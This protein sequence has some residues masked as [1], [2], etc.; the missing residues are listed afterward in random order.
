MTFPAFQ[1]TPPM[2]YVS[3]GAIDT[4]LFHR[5]LTTWDR[6]REAKKQ[7]A[8]KGFSFKYGDTTYSIKLVWAD[9]EEQY[10][11]WFAQITQS[12]R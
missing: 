11:V 9:G 7:A 12:M 5:G 4:W 8:D 10:G 6:R 3:A 2:D 1:Y